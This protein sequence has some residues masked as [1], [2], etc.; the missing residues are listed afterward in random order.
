MAAEGLDMAAEG[1]E[2]ENAEQLKAALASGSSQSSIWRK[3]R[4][5]CPEC[6]TR[7]WLERRNYVMMWG[8]PDLFCGKCNIK[9]RNMDYG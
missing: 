1:L 7:A 9:I 2:F 6:L 5:T 8:D 4:N 3:A